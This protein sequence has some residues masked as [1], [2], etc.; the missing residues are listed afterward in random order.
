MFDN[1]LISKLHYFTIYWLNYIIIIIMYKQICLASLFWCVIV[2]AL[3]WVYWSD[4]QAHC[5]VYTR[6]VPFLPSSQSTQTVDRSA[7]IWGLSSHRCRHPVGSSLVWTI[8]ETR[9][10]CFPS[11]NRILCWMIFEASFLLTD[12]ESFFLHEKWRFAHNC[13]STKYI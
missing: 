3:E 4:Y 11:W 1:E 7:L 10:C 8:H 5:S 2:P 6:W 12:I 13:Y 9:H